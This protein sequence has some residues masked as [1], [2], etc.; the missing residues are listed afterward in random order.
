MTAPLRQI[1][2]A[3]WP[4]DTVLIANYRAEIALRYQ[5]RRV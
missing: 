1:F 2:P 5:T 4:F 3:S